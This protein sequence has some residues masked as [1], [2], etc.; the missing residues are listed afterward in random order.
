[1]SKQCTMHSQFKGSSSMGS[2]LARLGYSNQFLLRSV[3][4]LST[5]GTL[6]DAA[7]G[8]KDLGVIQIVRTLSR[9]ESDQSVRFIHFENFLHTFSR[10]RGEGLKIVGFSVR[11]I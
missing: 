3:E 1:M 4:H 5:R 11:T 2:T 6:V 9:G 8:L 7:I 10:A